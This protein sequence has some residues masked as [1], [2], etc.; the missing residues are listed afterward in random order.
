MP[1]QSRTERLRR[2]ERP[3]FTEHRWV[4]ALLE[5]R[6]HDGEKCFSVGGCWDTRTKRYVN[7]PVT[8]HVYVL[9]E[10]Q[11][12]IGE[13][14]ARWIEA[15]RP[16]AKRKRIL[17]G[18]GN[19]GSGK[20][21]VLAGVA[22]VAI[23][24]LFP[25]GILF[26]INLTAKQ[27]RE[28]LEAIREVSAD[29]WVTSDVNDLRD[30]RTE[31]VTGSLINWLS[32]Q[33]PRAIRQA[34]LPIR[35]VLI[36][37]GQDQPE[38]VFVNAIAATRNTGGLLG[39]A[40]NPPQTESGDWVAALWQAIEA[41]EVNGERFLLDNKLN[42]AI[43]Q[44]AVDD[45]AAAIRAVNKDAAAADAD[46][47]FK[48]SGD[49]AYPA[50][51]P[52]PRER[53][54]HQG[55]PPQ[56]G[57]TDVTREL[58]G[59]VVHSALGFDYVCGVD[60]Q[61]TPGVCGSIAKIYRDERGELVLHVIEPIAVR[62][63]EG[64]FSGALHAAGYRPTT[65]M[66]GPTVL[67]IGDATGA[68]QNA[69]HRWNE[70]TSYKAIRSDGWVVAP[71]MKHWKHGTPWNPLVRDSRA[72]M[73]AAFSN[74]QILLGEKCKLPGDGFA[75]LVE[76]FRRAKVGPRGGLIEKG[77]FQHGPD[78]IRYLAWRF[79]PRPKPPAAPPIDPAF[80]DKMR[81]IKIFGG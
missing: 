9:Q 56:L 78:G 80:L 31:L 13:A 34:G 38:R 23:G 75:S 24:L 47:V 8:P 67:L 44:D 18:G 32:A 15:A 57:W 39:I 59:D 60:W 73:H 11:R 69:E 43:D 5:V 16:G 54:G 28:C 63:V 48:L 74:R 53:G 50:F 6:Y 46:G 2:L 36:N 10:S 79:L 61:K 52:Q 29:G 58:S 30:P 71:P 37:E 7:R 65:G 25:G 33:N 81:T 4:S 49:I 72:Q 45:I 66:G 68:R 20:T 64:D 77:G 19:R 40:T 26:G 1:A 41:G 17:M 76:S 51:I 14:L 35:Y 62:G 70:P 12:E 55:E 3:T 42:R 21:W 27:K 22:M